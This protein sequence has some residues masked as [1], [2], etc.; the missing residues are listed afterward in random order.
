MPSA[1]WRACSARPERRPKEAEWSGH[2]DKLAKAFLEAFWREDHFGE[3]VHPEHGLVDT[4]GLSDVNW[5][6]VAFGLAD[7][8]QLERLWPRLMGEPAFWAGDMPTQIVTKPF[9]YEK[10][11]SSRSPDCPA[12]PLNDV[13]A[14]GRVW[15]L[16]AMACQRMKA[17]AR[18]VDSVRKVCRAAK[19]TAI[20]ASGTISSPTAPCRRTARRS[21]ANTPRSWR[22]WCSATGKSSFHNPGQASADGPPSSGSRQPPQRQS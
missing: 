18:L 15:Y 2:A 13:A 17:R 12:D 9:A 22:G 21:I 10:W 16:E 5:A 8:R 4:H 6:A 14:M 11:E 1:N 20:G 3:Y 7:D 19:G